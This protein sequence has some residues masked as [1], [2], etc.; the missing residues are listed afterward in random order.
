MI[1][2]EI[3]KEFIFTLDIKHIIINY[4]NLTT[5]ITIFNL[6]IPLLYNIP[7]YQ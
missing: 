3:I 5:F 6:I 4:K 7:A 1:Y 2:I